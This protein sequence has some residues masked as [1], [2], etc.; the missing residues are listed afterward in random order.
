[1]CAPKNAASRRKQSIAMLALALSWK[2]ATEAASAKVYVHM[3]IQQ[4]WDI[5]DKI[6]QEVKFAIQ[7]RAAFILLGNKKSSL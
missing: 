5:F 1:M 6:W 4:Y 2:E 7:L 3:Y